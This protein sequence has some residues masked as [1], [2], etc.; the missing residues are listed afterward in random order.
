[1][2][3]IHGVKIRYAL[4][5]KRDLASIFA[6]LAERSPQAKRLVAA[7]LSDAIRVIVDNPAIGMR[8]Q[9]PGIFVKFVPKSA[10]RIFYRVQGETIEIIHIRHSAR[11]PWLL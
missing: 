10:Y 2:E 9:R 8:T 4:A 6:Y 1:M 5:A 7:R 3:E 11:R